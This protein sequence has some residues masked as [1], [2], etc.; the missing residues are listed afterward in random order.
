M[1]KSCFRVIRNLIIVSL[2]VVALLIFPE[3]IVNAKTDPV[4]QIYNYTGAGPRLHYR[5]GSVTFIFKANVSGTVTAT[6][7]NYTYAD[8]SGH[9]SASSNLGVNQERY[10]YVRG[11]EVT[12]NPNT[13]IIVEFVPDDT[14]TY[15]N[16]STTIPI[17][18]IEKATPSLS[19]V[20]EDGSV[21]INNEE[22]FSATTGLAGTLQ[23]TIED[24]TYA[25]LVTN[26]NE[27]I[28]G[29][30]TITYR[31]TNITSNPI[32]VSVKFTPTDT[33]HYNT[34]TRNYTITKVICTEHIGGTHANG[35]TC[36]IC[37]EVYQNHTMSTEWSSDATKHWHACTFEGCNYVENEGNHTGGTHANG[38][39]CTICGEVYQDHTMST[40]W[41][42]DATKHWHACTF[43]GCNYVENEGNHTGGTHANGGTC[44][45]CG[46]SYQNHTMNTS[47][48]GDT[49][50]HWHS[51]TFEGCDYVA[52]KGE[53]TGGTHANGGTCSICG[54]VYQDHTRS[55]EWVINE[56]SHWHICNFMGCDEIFDEGLHTGGNHANNG[57][58]TVCNQ[59][60]Q[61]HGTGEV[62]EYV[63]T[64]TTHTPIYRCTFNEC[65]ELITGDIENHMMDS[66]R[67]IDDEY[68]ERY[69]VKCNYRIV[70]AHSGGTHNNY[71]MCVACNSNYQ[72]HGESTDVKEYN[73]SVFGHTSIYKCKCPTCNKT[74]IGNL[75]EHVDEDGNLICDVCEYEMQ[76]P[77]IFPPVATIA[78][79][80]P[81]Y[82]LNNE[83]GSTTRN[84]TMKITATDDN[85]ITQMALANENSRGTINWITYAEET[86]WT[87]S[88]GDGIKTVYLMLKDEF[89]NVS[90]SFTNP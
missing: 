60:Y 72:V 10:F 58:C 50:E 4:V 28:N 83:E 31:G 61:V 65:D 78:L 55:S 32:N 22:S 90:V 12:S 14:N 82:S 40:E 6:L 33:N 8:F 38:G 80:N 89:G 37:G 42:N 29:T 11:N 74:Y 64:G 39:T 9:T 7:S 77:D 71:G 75:F 54:G 48:S 23:I 66:N 13:N 1:N 41:S 3:K 76:N 43:E 34:V 56:T 79:K 44:S 84:V 67:K 18:S 30:K 46:V 49:T 73:T 62:S 68:H 35:G 2:F 59:L 36:T 25:N 53:H 57:V 63:T 26:A 81:K 88:E 86:P 20:P 52:D 15:N 5:D 17:L 85:N 19:L 51:C 47:W 16:F 69:C 45:T 27:S 24:T 70:E 87:L 21:G